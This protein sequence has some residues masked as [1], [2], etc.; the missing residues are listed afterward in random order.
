MKIVNPRRAFFCLMAMLSLS[1]IGLTATSAPAA[2]ITVTSTGDT[3]AVDNKVTLRE[4]ITSANTNANANADVVAVGIYGNDTI[5][6]AIPTSDPNFN[7]G[8]NT[9]TITLTTTLPA[10][11]TN[12]NITGPTTAIVKIDGAGA[13]QIF[14]MTAGTV[15]L[16]NLTITNGKGANGIAGSSGAGA[17]GAPGA[18]GGGAGGSGGTGFGGVGGAGETG[19]LNLSGGDL[20]IDNC[21]ISNNV[22]GNGG[23]GATGTGGGGG[24]GGAAAA[25]TGGAGGAGGLGF[26]GAGGNGGAGGVNSSSAGSLTIS[27]STFAN[28]IG[29][30]SGAAGLGVGGPGGQGG[31]GSGGAGGAG[32][33]AAAG[34][35]GGGGAGGP[36]GLNVSNGTTQI[37]DSTFNN[38]KAGD[39]GDGGGGVGGSGGVGG[40]GAG[41]GGAGGVGGDGAAGFGGFGGS[42]T[43][44][45]MFFKASTT[46]KITRCTFSNNFGSAASS[47]AGGL[48][49]GGGGAVGGKGAPSNNGGAAGAGGAGFGGFGTAGVVGG[50]AVGSGNLTVSNSTFAA[51]AGKIG[52]PGGLG[53]GG[54]GGAGGAGG[55][56]AGVNAGAGGSGGAGFGGFAGPGGSGAFNPTVGAASLS[57]STLT[58][59]TAGNGNAG[60]IGIAGS[61][62]SGGTGG[63]NGNGGG[64]GAGGSGFGGFG[65]DGAG[66]GMTVGASISVGNTIIA[67][68][69]GG[70]GGAGA[71]GLNGFGGAGGPGNGAGV[72]GAPGALGS[73]LPGA[74]GAPGGADVQG[75]VTSDG[76]NLVGSSSG[77]SGFTQP[78][79]QLNVDPKLDPAG[80]QDNGG[81]TKTFA[82]QS[83]SPAIDKGKDISVSFKDQRSFNRPIDFLS[84]P[85]AVGGDGSDIG[86]FEIQTS[87]SISNQTVT[88]GNGGSLNAVFTVTLADALAQ[89]VTVD[90]FT[91][92]GTATE[93]SDYTAVNGTLTFFPGQTTRTISVPVNGDTLPEPDETFTVNLMNP[94]NAT[95]TN[96]QGIG[97][98]VNDDIGTLQLSIG[99]QAVTEGNSGSSLAVFTVTLSGAS[100]QSVSVDYGTANGSATNPSDYT[101][102]NGTLVFLPGQTSKTISVPVNG[103]TTPEGNETFVVNLTNPVN[104]TILVGQG[105][106]TINDDDATSIFQFSAATASVSENAGSAT[107]TVTRTGDTA[108]AASVKFETSDGSASQKT[109]Y[110]FGYGTVQFA[111]GETSKPVK[112]LIVNDVFV[113]PT[114]TFV[115]TLSNPSGNCALGS[116]SSITVTI[117]DDDLG[118]AANPIDT[119]GF[120]VRQQ[121]LDFLG[122][123]PDASGLTFWTNN[124]TSCG[125][126]A[127]CTAAKRVDTSAAFFLSI[128]FQETSGNVVRTQRVAFGRQSNDQFNRVPYLQFMRDTRQ[129][130]QGVIIGQPGA[131]ALLEAN[132]AFY[133]EQIVLSTEFTTRFP[134]APG[135][136][137]VDALYAS[138]GVTPTAAE[139]NAAINAFG[140]GGTPGRIA[141]LRSVVDSASIRAADFTPSFV[142]AQY[143]GYLRRNPT[144]APDFSDAGYQFWLTKLNSF[145]GDFRAADM[146][147]SFITSG[148]Y[149][150]RFGTP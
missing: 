87:L 75:S 60:G 48:G 95:I 108:G 148:E 40:N 121:Y 41:A 118:P 34:F 56:G 70:A 1:L 127:A 100:A 128:E 9:Y 134:P 123:E 20:T 74:P 86:A 46:L 77:S 93:P 27:R 6:F 5:N 141:A 112:I 97:T 117:N 38:N 124:I 101:A 135:P 72:P 98:I 31:A 119:A 150:G 85:N 49:F 89:T 102:V 125:A 139:R 144:D 109:D 76:Y 62:G 80:L 96:G 64:G 133:A 145:N 12:M 90:Y 67:G 57:N 110:T 88:E 15:I 33:T 120:F 4:A 53:I 111:P 45:G 138:A 69:T 73:A 25:G 140:A 30:N 47:G 137:Y 115:V 146:V 59:N 104:A 92:N 91:A 83:I 37:S 35:G 147:K 113:D 129:V 55:A 26:G 84:R 65:S 39:T 23:A 58:L 63:T 142:L 105:T 107:V 106:G 126:D 24:T 136:V 149:R 81:L 82:L 131:D 130:G 143:Y 13:V 122:R 19:G 54:S 17:A 79:D 61:G 16:S 50:L 66:G 51:N 44:G 10:L 42:P 29:G 71:I 28:N 116:P 22:G 21:V 103:D 3:V 132:K 18:P 2:T 11:T 78:S 52:G 32:G 36:G 43:A 8:T 14:S 99:N 114:E 94:A 68:N 7:G